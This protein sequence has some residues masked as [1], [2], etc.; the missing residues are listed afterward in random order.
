MRIVAG[1]SS[2]VQCLLS[3]GPYTTLSH[4]VQAQENVSAAAVPETYDMTHE[5]LI[6]P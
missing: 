2:V 4:R 5:N 3:G 6:R 1:P